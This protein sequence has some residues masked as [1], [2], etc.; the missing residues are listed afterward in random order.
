MQRSE[1]GIEF[2]SVLGLPPVEFVQLAADLGCRRIGIALEPI[3]L[4]KCYAKWSLRTDAALRQNVLNALRDG[5]VSVALGEGFI[6]WPNKDIREVRADLDA[7]RELGAQQVNLIALDPDRARS[8][9]QCAVFAELAGERGMGAT[10]EFMPGLPIGDLKTAGAAI[11]HAGKANL[12][13]LI[14]AMHFFRSGSAVS[15]LAE[16]DPS[17][18]GYVQIC[19]VPVVSAGASY[20]DEARYARLPPGQGQ[21]PLLEFLEALPERVAMGVEVPMMARAE[22]GVGPRERLAPCLA[23]T[24][25]LIKKAGAGR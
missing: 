1:L 18:I 13:V 6:A 12:R 23:A 25:D 5:G 15:Q 11:Q 19:D 16:F 22:A 3:V 2:I 7:M 20:A 24:W 4:A 17:L 21:L 8:F 14:D 10:L 9:D